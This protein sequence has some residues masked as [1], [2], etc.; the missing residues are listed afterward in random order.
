MTKQRRLTKQSRL[1]KQRRLSKR[2]GGG[3]KGSVKTKSSRKTKSVD[4]MMKARS[5]PNKLSTMKSRAD[6]K[7][8]KECE[9]NLKLS[10]KEINECD[11]SRKSWEAATNKAWGELDNMEW[12]K[13]KHKDRYTEL[14]KENEDRY[15]ELLK[16]LRRSLHIYGTHQEE[17]DKINELL[18]KIPS[19]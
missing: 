5:A 12:W 14:L 17:L 11:K 15:T 13:N 6:N 16:T 4:D 2:G 10:R 1:T 19:K 7:K 3:S 8:L 9:K 18:K